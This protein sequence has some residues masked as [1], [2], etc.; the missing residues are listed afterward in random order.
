MN[1][2]KQSGL[3]G[4]LRSSTGQ[5]NKSVDKTSLLQYDHVDGNNKRHSELSNEHTQLEVSS[6]GFFCSCVINTSVYVSVN[7]AGGTWLFYGIW[8]KFLISGSTAAYGI[9][10]AS[11]IQLHNLP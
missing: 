1:A 4:L 6:R 2:A 3:V 9:S 8:S 5:R 11:V 7:C 10:C